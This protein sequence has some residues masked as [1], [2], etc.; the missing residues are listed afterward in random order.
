LPLPAVAVEPVVGLVEPVE[1]LV[2]PLVFQAV[3]VKVPVVLAEL[4]AL[5]A[6][7]VLPMEQQLQLELLAL[8]AKVEPVVTLTPQA[9]RLPVV[10]AAVAVTT[11]VV[12][13]EQTLTQPEPMVAV[14]ELDPVMPML[15]SCNQFPML[16]LASLA[17]AK[18][19][20]HISLAQQSQPSL[21][22]VHLAMRFPQYSTSALVKA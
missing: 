3:A 7:V 2:A 4:L 19:P 12:A 6:L 5:V 1:Q 8:S 9:H 17:M 21:H 18:L 22:L 10:A 15:R 20:S 11:V 14:V 13:V 16:L